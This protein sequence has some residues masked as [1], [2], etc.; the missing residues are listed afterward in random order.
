VPAS[1]FGIDLAGDTR[2][3]PS[4]LPVRRRG[5]I[6]YDGKEI[7]SIC[8]HEFD[9]EHFFCNFDFLGFERDLW[10]H[11]FVETTDNDNMLHLS[12][13]EWRITGFWT[14]TETTSG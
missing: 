4:F 9:R 1:P 14:P 8:L 6:L 12:S 11:Q 13:F 10:Q 2:I 7:T 3:P 5:P